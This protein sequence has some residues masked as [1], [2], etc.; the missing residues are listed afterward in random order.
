MQSKLKACH[1][2]NDNINRG[3]VEIW[4]ASYPGSTSKSLLELSV[5]HVLGWD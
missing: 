4:Y 5:G 2:D 3:Y 1:N